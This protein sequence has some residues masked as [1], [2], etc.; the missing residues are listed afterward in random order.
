[1]VERGIIIGYLDNIFRFDNL[2]IRVE[3]VRIMVISLNFLIKVI[4]NLFFK[5]VLKDYWVYFYIEIVKYYL[6]GFRI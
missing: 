6:I 2:V 3:F 4:D 1:M 5:D